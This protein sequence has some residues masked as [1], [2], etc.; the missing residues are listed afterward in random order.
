MKI[1]K[2]CGSILE[3]DAAFCNECGAKYEDSEETKT[4]EAGK[5]NN[6]TIQ[7]N[8]T[9]IPVGN[10]DEPEVTF[11]DL[12][13]EAGNS[14]GKVAAATGK[15]VGEKALEIKQNYEKSAAES[16][17]STVVLADGEIPVREYNVTK[18]FL[19]K[20]PGKLLV[21][22]KRIIF[23]S[24]SLGSRVVA[25]TPINTVNSIYIFDGR[26]LNWIEIIIS[27]IL[28]YISYR[29]FKETGFDSYYSYYSY[30]SLWEFIAT[31][32][33]RNLRVILLLVGC[34]L[35]YLGTRKALFLSITSSGSG[36]G[37]SV[38][39]GNTTGIAHY[40]LNGYSGPDTIKVMNE[41]GAVV[42]DLQQLGDLAINKWKN[43]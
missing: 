37:L 35:M 11:M 23:Y 10:T 41:I 42:L 28:L 34:L 4:E 30:Y 3:D 39:R 29:M 19:F 25:S 5:V 2:N 16:A 18:M 22:N 14:I 6:E 13:K 24:G 1:C 20:V 31:F 15:T 17:N 27:I 36:Y 33:V 12:A 26:S 38:G 8:E 32:F 43:I 40:A 21:T 7:S 9:Q